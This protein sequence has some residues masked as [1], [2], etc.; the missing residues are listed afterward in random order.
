MRN[1]PSRSA[2]YRAASALLVLLLAGSL[3]GCAALDPDAHADALAQPAH[4]QRETVDTG[5]FVLT[6]FSHIS[7]PGK[8][9]RVYIEGDGLAWLSRTE[10]SLDPTPRQAAGLALAA[11]DP[12][13]NVVYLARPC[14]FTPMAMNPR[15]GIP[16]W[17][18]KRFA[19]DVIASMNDAVNHF[20]AL[21]PGQPVEL[22]GYS[23]GGAVAVLIAA[24]RTDVASI[25]T[26]AGNLDDEFVNRLHGVSPMPESENAIDFASRV[27][28]IP[29]IHFSGADDETV[30]P[31]VAQRFIEAAGKQCARALTVPGMSHDGDWS[32]RWPALLSVAPACAIP[33]SGQ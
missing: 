18:G 26:V 5:R 4:L 6:A 1:R 31:S 23:G 11:Q 20:A 3:A 15:C 9:L 30:P 28:A 24:R 16:Y 25:R 17:T 7:Q 32:R 14:Q 29:Q 8:P 21:T 10:P 19:P 22:V 12:A 33:A 27:A 2:A 13:P